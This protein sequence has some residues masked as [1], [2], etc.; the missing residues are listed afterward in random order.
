MYPPLFALAGLAIPLLYTNPK[1]IEIEAFDL[2]PDD[3]EFWTRHHLAG[4][5]AVGYRRG[6]MP[7]FAL[8]A[9]GRRP[10]GPAR[11]LPLADRA[12]LSNS[13]GK[14]TAVAAE[15]LKALGVPFTWFTSG[16]PLPSGLIAAARRFTEVSGV[17]AWIVA[18][19]EVAWKA[20]DTDY[21]AETDGQVV[22]R[23][24][25][26]ASDMA[27]CLTLFQPLV[28]ICAA[29]VAECKGARYVLFANERS[30]SRCGF[31]W[32]GRSVNPHY[33]KS[34]EL[35]RDLARYFERRLN[36]SLRYASLTMPFYDV[37]LASLFCRLKSLR[38][39][40]RRIHELQ[41]G[42]LVWTLFE[43]RNRVRAL[44][45]F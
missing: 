36:P 22:E 44:T 9:S 29:L 31:E 14:D 21:Q 11:E 41:L 42:S 18:N 19:W 32:R 7:D 5:L 25:P 38:A 8:H 24:L 2:D 1:R 37:Q 35:E 17:A 3:R 27:A 12:L 4:M 30:A 26:G 40:S 13:G 16:I 33:N 6:L 34:W 28:A 43:M 23:F 15:L 20:H 10:L 39:V 45:A